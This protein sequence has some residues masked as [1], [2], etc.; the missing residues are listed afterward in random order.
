MADNDPANY[1]L[2][3]NK[4]SRELEAFGGPWAPLNLE[5]DSLVV[6]IPGMGTVTPNANAPILAT[7]V[8]GN[9]TLNGPVNGLDGQ[10]IIFRLLQ[11]GTGHTVTLATGMGNFKFG[12]DITSFTASGAG[13]MDYVGT[14]YNAAANVWN[15]VAVIQGF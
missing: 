15:V 9:L 1:L 13:M 6:T 8:M 10:K 11:D 12:T 2:R 7:T 3:F 5:N 4:I 14:I